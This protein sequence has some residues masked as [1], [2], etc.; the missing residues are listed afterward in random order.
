[1]ETP[2]ESA[3]A[4]NIQ[5]AAAVGEPEVASAGTL[6]IAAIVTA[7]EERVA[8]IF[9]D[10]RRTAAVLASEAEGPDSA[11][12]ARR[13][14]LARARRELTDSA[15]ALAV[16]FEAMLDLLEAAEAELGG[17]EPPPPHED[18]V[19]A[20]RMTVRERRRVTFAQEA[21]APGG[22]GAVAPAADDPPHGKAGRRRWWRLW[23]REAA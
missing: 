11:T 9:G 14:E 1:M 20:F 4:L 8:E 5:L 12:A 18:R 22:A 16:R 17:A 7:T 2:A 15:S 19:D 6:A 23:T 3:A 13:R 21:T 10:A